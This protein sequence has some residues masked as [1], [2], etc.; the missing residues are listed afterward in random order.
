MGWKLDWRRFRV[1]LAEKYAVGT[2]YIF[3]GYLP[4]NERLYRFLQQ[5]NYV[6]FKPLIV[7][8]GGKPK[9]NVDSDLT[10]QAMLDYPR[11][12]RAVI[13]SSDG[14]FYRL[15]D[16]LYTQE[17]L[18]AVMSPERSNCSSLL[19]QSAKER[20]RFLDELR[21]RLEYVPRKK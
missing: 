20:M 14:D 10:F 12:E 11:Y 7:P 5:A 21:K 15:V 4:A 13:V 17:K 19:K 9:G 16:H 3:I 6:V 1:L 2:A 8:K 18:A